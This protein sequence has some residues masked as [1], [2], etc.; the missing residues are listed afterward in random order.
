MTAFER[1]YEME[2]SALLMI[3]IIVF[4]S[5]QVM[6]RTFGFESTWVP[7]AASLMVI[8]MVFLTL[9][10]MRIDREH[11]RV[12][13]FYN[14]YPERVQTLLDLAARLTVI[15]VSLVMVYA[16]VI[17]MFEFSHVRTPGAGIPT[18]VLFFAGFIGFL[19]YG[20]AYVYDF[21]SFLHNALNDRSSYGTDD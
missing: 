10:R 13:F 12:D 8:F 11:I 2:L 14:R 19:L 6:G 17:T 7:E 20:A 5:Y 15:G 1:E 9:G 16:T 21:K 4:M 18:P 3:V